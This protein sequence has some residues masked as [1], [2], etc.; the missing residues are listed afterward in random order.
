MICECPSFFSA[1]RISQIFQISKWSSRGELYWR[2]QYWVSSSDAIR[3]LR[4]CILTSNWWWTRTRM[5][6]SSYDSS[7]TWSRD[8][9]KRNRRRRMISYSYTSP[10][11]P[12]HPPPSYT[13]A[14]SEGGVTVKVNQPI[15]YQLISFKSVF[16]WK[17][18]LFP[19]DI[20]QFPPCAVQLV[21]LKVFNE[22]F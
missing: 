15:F 8:L 4:S 3:N 21:S 2:L 11:C 14:Q 1:S 7:S 16:L 22:L 9:G 17:Y 5:I 18:D 20:H 12:P 6:R 10:S 19:F 13:E